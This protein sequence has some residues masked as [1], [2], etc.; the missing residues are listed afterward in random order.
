MAS[1]SAY[2]QATGPR[3]ATAMSEIGADWTCRKQGGDPVNAGDVKHH[4][5]PLYTYILYLDLLVMLY[6]IMII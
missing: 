5:N 2:P 1:S 3:P 6:I 4:Y